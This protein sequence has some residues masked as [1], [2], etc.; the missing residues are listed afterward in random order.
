MQFI[1]IPQV[2]AWR[3]LRFELLDEHVMLRLKPLLGPTDG[4]VLR[5]SASSA[6]G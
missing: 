1:V 2:P 5:A 4:V 6:F 3:C